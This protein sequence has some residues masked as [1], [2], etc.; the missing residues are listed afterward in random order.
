[1][2][3]SPASTPVSP[4]KLG[5]SRVCHDVR[6]GKAR[7]CS[8]IPR[9]G[10][11]TDKRLGALASSSPGLGASRPGAAGSLSDREGGAV[12]LQRACLTLPASSCRRQGRLSL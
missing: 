3:A 4:A 11:L 9:L 1:M 10:R 12:G 2:P 6:R 8:V 7:L 5:V